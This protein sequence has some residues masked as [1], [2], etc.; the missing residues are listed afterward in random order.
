MVG[1]SKSLRSGGPK[2]RL[3]KAISTQN[4]LKTGVYTQ[5]DLLP[6]EDAREHA[7]LEQLL[8]YDLKPIGMV[9]TTLVKMLAQ[10]S[11]KRLRLE[12]METRVLADCLAKLPSLSDLQKVGINNYPASSEPYVANPDLITS[13][14]AKG[15]RQV[16]WA[17]EEFRQRGLREELLSGLENNFP[18][19]YQKLKAILSELSGESLSDFDMAH[20][21][22]YWGAPSA[23]IA[24]AVEKLIAHYQGKLWAIE[25]YERLLKAKQEVEDK[26]LLEFLKENST[27][28]AH[29]DLDRAYSRALKELRAQQNWRKNQGVIKDVVTS[30][31]VIKKTKK[32]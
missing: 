3:G 23:P 17:L 5:V 12:K 29:D 13:L 11:W 22:Y 20:S 8:I 28:R 16:I 26:R 4:S 21:Q 18:D 7:A 25:N 32:K 19:V 30:V 2:S 24:D 15:I 9:E 10:I 1:Q 27:Q 14:N 6:H 31:K